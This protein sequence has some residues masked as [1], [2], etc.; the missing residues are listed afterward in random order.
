MASLRQEATDAAAAYVDTAMAQEADEAYFDF[1]YEGAYL[2]VS[3]VYDDIGD[4][5]Q[6]SEPLATDVGFAL[7]VMGEP[8]VDFDGDKFAHPGGG[9]GWLRSS[10]TT[11]GDY[12]AA[13][14]RMK[15]S[16][17]DW[18]NIKATMQSVAAAHIRVGMP[19]SVLAYEYAFDHDREGLAFI[20]ALDGDGHGVQVRDGERL[21]TPFDAADALGSLIS[22]P[23]VAGLTRDDESSTYRLGRGAPRAGAG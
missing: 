23:E 13:L 14:S 19:E 16:A 9:Y 12:E 20:G 8:D 5:V 3:D 15:Q 21:T 22:D 4:E 11:Y 17:D 1:S 6:L 10:E 7:R 2:V 18:L